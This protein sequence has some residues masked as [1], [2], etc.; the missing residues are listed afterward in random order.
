MEGKKDG[1]LKE[2]RK[3]GRKEGALKEGRKEGRKEAGAYPCGNC[4]Y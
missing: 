2:G 3:N 1:A 4:F